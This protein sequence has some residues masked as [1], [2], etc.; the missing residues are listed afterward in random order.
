LIL[1]SL[2]TNSTYYFS[3]D[4]FNENGI[5]PSRAIQEVR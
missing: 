1:I 2:N 3:I 4:S 5:T